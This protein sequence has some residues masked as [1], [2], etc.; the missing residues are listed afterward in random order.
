MNKLYF[1]LKILHTNNNDKITDANH[2]QETL[3]E[4]WIRYNCNNHK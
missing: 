4:P 2:L 1:S 3:E